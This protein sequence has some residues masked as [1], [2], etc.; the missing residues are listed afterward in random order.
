MYMDVKDC[1]TISKGGDSVRDYSVTFEV[2]AIAIWT[3]SIVSAAMLAAT[4]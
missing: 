3:T 4:S 2:S 1:I